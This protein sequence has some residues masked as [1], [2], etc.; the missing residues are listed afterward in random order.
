MTNKNSF[1]AIV[2]AALAIIAVILLIKFKNQEKS[3]S[4]PKEFLK[5]SAPAVKSPL[6]TIDIKVG[7]GKEAKN[8]DIIEVNY[9]GTL[10]N[11]VKFDSSYDRNQSFVFTLGAGEVIQG[12]DI[13]LLGMKMGGKRKLIIPSNLAYGKAGAGDAIPPDATLV[14]E[15]ELLAIK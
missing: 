3:K 10:E 9:L 2:I 8:G 11:G 14:F 7:D 4:L 12:W 5:A 1:L 15:V 13:G 6:Q